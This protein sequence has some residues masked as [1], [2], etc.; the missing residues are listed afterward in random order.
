MLQVVL[1]VIGAVA[2]GR[3]RGVA[4]RPG[5]NL[6]GQAPGRAVQVQWLTQG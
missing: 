6:E 1:T 2:P 3:R 4:D 5:G